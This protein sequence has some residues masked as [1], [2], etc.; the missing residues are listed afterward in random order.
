MTDEWVLYLIP[1][2]GFL[3]QQ[4]FGAE[5]D[6]VPSEITGIQLSLVPSEPGFD[7]WIDDMQFAE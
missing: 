6:F 3:E 2:E 4:G 1:F 7:I 5:V